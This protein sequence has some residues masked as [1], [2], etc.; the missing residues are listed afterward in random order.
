MNDLSHSE[1]HEMGACGGEFAACPE[2]DVEM[3]RRMKVAAKAAI[4]CALCDREIN[5][6]L[7]CRSCIPPR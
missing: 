4:M 5:G 7:Y 3:A 6:G 1:L 2:C